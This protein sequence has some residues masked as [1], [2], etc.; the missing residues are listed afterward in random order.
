MIAIVL[1]EQPVWQRLPVEPYQ[2]HQDGIL[3]LY[4]TIHSS[5][6][7]QNLYGL[8]DQYVLSNCKK[9]VPVLSTHDPCHATGHPAP[10]KQIQVFVVDHEFHCQ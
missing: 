3:T 10:K 5:A 1:Q 8:S 9:E 6:T 7:I 2:F 4:H